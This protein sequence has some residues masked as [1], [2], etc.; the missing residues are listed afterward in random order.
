MIIN[1]KS[2]KYLYELMSI[3]LALFNWDYKIGAILE[4]QYPNTFN[5]G[6]TLLNKIY[7]THSYGEKKD[8]EELIEINYEDKIILSYCDKARVPKF[9]YEIL[10]LM[11]HEKE[12]PNLFTLKRVLLNFAKNLFQHDR[13]SR[14]VFFLQNADKFVPKS[15]AKKLLLLGRAE[16]GKTTI[17]KI[18]FEGLSPK[19]LLFNPLE[20]TRGITP[21]VYS[22]FD[23][24]LGIFDSAGQELNFLLTDK[25]EQNLAFE[26][27]E[28]VIYLIDI[29]TWMSKKEDIIQE[30]NHIKSLIHAMENK[31]KLI[32]FLHKI[33]LINQE[34]R[35]Q[36]F[37]QIR[38]V[39]ENQLKLKIYFTSIHPDLI[40]NL[41]NAFYDILSSFSR[42]TSYLKA[43][44]DNIIKDT[45]KIMCFIT[46]QNNSIILQ[47]MTPDFSPLLINHSHKLIVQLNK[48]FQDM[49]D[50]DE[51]SHLII[52]GKKNLNI[53][54][55]SLNITKF[56]LKNLICIAEDLNANKLIGLAGR[57]RLEI[58]KI[59]FLKNVD[60]NNNE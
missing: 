6:I 30:V 47:T 12:K 15:T 49:T 7:M 13:E 60:G 23:L 35:N 32:I 26:N 21:T 11:L 48:T 34:I 41:Y 51:I 56:N 9:G 27:T 28:I 10:I 44:I 31:A 40:Y 42:E 1:S 55:N 20:P 18:V 59:Y 43:A 52:S 17:K 57:I 19:E 14:K 3:G 54:M 24:Q 36:E 16:T 5:I 4:V 8:S 46:N 22:W 2:K 37:D 39:F 25:E 58:N 53:I 50:K 45:P 29:S 33:D 38:E